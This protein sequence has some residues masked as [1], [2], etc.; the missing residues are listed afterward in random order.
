MQVMRDP[1]PV[2]EHASRLPGIA[3]R[4]CVEMGKHFKSV[5]DM[6]NAT[7]DRFEKVPGIGKKG[8][9][10]IMKHIDEPNPHYLTE[11]GPE[12]AA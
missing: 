5:R 2:E 4:K 6:L 7:R 3:D 10:A 9:L 11:N 8:S 1:T 12:T